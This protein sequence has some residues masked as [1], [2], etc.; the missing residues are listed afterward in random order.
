METTVIVVSE[1]TIFRLIGEF[2]G[3]HFDPE[4]ETYVGCDALAT[5]LEAG[6]ILD[7]VV[8]VEQHSRGGRCITVYNFKVS[9]EMKTCTL[10]VVA[11]PIIER[12]MNH[13]R[14]NALPAIS[15]GDCED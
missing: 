5:L 12:I 1:K 6:W 13:L 15:N 4:S 11:N 14:L 2:K 10:K 8:E 3:R 9:N 7:P